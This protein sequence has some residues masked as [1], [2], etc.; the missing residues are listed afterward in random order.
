[1]SGM[2]INSIN[3]ASF[4]IN[5]SSSQKL[6]DVTKKKLEY[7]GVDTTNIKTEAQGQTE[8][9]IAIQKEM[10]KAQ[11][12]NHGGSEAMIK[13]QAKDLASQVNASIS[14]NEKVGA[15]LTKVASKISELKQAAGTDEMKLANVQ[16]YQ[17]QYDAIAS[18][19]SNMQSAR[20]Q[21]STGMDGLASYNKVLLGLR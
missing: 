19:F 1:M 15:I 2:P 16:Q 14:S 12:A 6:T 9:T 17:S 21:L 7:L 3:N 10:Q 13:A 4:A 18:S 11:A 20:N 5:A 8:L